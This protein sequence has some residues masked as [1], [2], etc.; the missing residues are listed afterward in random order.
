MY[1]EEKVEYLLDMDDSAKSY[2]ERGMR[3]AANECS[4]YERGIQEL[5]NIDHRQRIDAIT[6]YNDM[7]DRLKEFLHSFAVDKKVVT[8]DD[9]NRFFNK[10]RSERNNAAQQIA[11]LQQPHFCR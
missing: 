10:M 6:A 3:R 9:I 5:A 8:E 11:G 1:R 2:E 7:K 4:T